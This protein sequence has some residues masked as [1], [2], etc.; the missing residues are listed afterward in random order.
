[1]DL[2]LIGE[3]DVKKPGYLTMMPMNKRLD[4]DESKSEESELDHDTILAGEQ[5]WV[6][7]FSLSSQRGEI[8]A[9]D[10]VSLTVFRSIEVI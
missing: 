2:Q 10:V 7:G 9:L 1:M 5:L 4:Q 6:S 3:I 8:H